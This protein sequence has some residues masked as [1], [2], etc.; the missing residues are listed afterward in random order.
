[1]LYRA[2]FNIVQRTICTNTHMF[3][4]SKNISKFNHGRYSLFVDCSHLQQ[5]L[6]FV[7]F[8][9]FKSKISISKHNKHEEQEQENEGE[10]DVD[11]YLNTEKAKIIKST[12][13]SLRLDVVAKVGFGISRT[14]LEKEFYKS[15]LRLNGNKCLKKSEMV[16]IGDEIDYIVSKSPDNPANLIVNRC[17]L[18]SAN[19]NSES[20]VILVKL[21]QN[22]SLLIEDYNDKWNKAK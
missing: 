15:N 2:V 10:L 18:L 12:V 20:D 7:T 8:K 6:A 14:K 3:C 21:V 11:D 19:I 17:I 16:Q 4:A 13:P 22:K 5:N 9:R 1:M